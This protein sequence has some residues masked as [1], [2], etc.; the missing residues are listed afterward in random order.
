ME[1][2]KFVGVCSVC[3]RRRI[4][5]KRK[6]IGDETWTLIPLQDGEKATWGLCPVHYE[7]AMAEARQLTSLRTATVAA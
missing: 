6:N 1:E 5:E 7:E 2:K 3:H 4:G